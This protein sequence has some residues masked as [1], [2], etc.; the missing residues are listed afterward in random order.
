MSAGTIWR[1]VTHGLRTLV[2]RRRFEQ[3]LDDELQHW[4]EMA[5][6]QHE[7]NGLAPEAA[8]RRARAE[9]GGI[10]ATRERVRGGSWEFFVDTL[11]RDLRY[12]GRTLRRSPAFSIAAILT[13][14][15]GI[16]GNTTIFSL[17]N[18]V[19]LRPP[20]HVRMP[21][22]L[23]SVYTSD[24]SGPPH[25]TSSYADFEDFRSA[26]NVFRD[27][28]A[29]APRSIDVGADDALE[30]EGMELVSPNYFDLLGVRLESGRGF[31]P[32]EGKAG[33]PVPVAV[34]GDR[35]WKRR[36][37]GRREAIGQVIQLAGTSFTIIGI[38]PHGFV[39]AFRGIE[40]QV[41]IPVAAAPLVGAGDGDLMSRGDRSYFVMARLAPGVSIEGARLTMA[42]VARRLFEQ[43]PATW[44]DLSGKG[45]RITL[46][47]EFA[48][49]I[50]PQVRAPALGFMGLLLAT[51]GLVLL[52]CCA[53]VASLMI[54]RA[55]R[56]TREMGVRLAL[57][58][59]R[60]R[61]LR[62]LLTESTML[63]LAGGVVGVLLSMAA[64]S[65]LVSVD[66]P[67]PF[68]LSLDLALDRRVFGFTAGVAL[69]T[70]I[71]F[72]IAPARRAVRAQVTGMLRG[73]GPTVVAGRRFTLQG[74]LVVS[75]V[76]VS[77]LLLVAALGFVRSLRAASHVDTGFAT[78]HLLLFDVAVRPGAKSAEPERDVAERVR[79][80]LTTTSGVVAASWGSASPLAL[81]ASRRA[82]DIE[83]YRAAPGEDMEHYFNNVGPDYFEAMKLPIV[84][85][86]GVTADDRAGAPG[87]V[88]VSET[89][90]KRFWPGENPIGKRI[91]DRRR[92]N[93][94]AEVVGVTRDARFASLTDAVPPY[95]YFSALQRPNGMVFHVRTLGAPAEMRDVI[96]ARLTSVVPD[97]QLLNMRTMDAQ[98]GVAL[99]PQRV[100]GSLLSLFGVVAMLLAA[101]G[102]YGVVAFGVAARS[103]EI[104]VRIALGA[105]SGDVMLLILRQGG[106]LVL[107]GLAV[108]VPLA[109]AA[110][111]L[112]QSLFIGRD[113]ANAVAFVGAALL[114]GSVTFVATWIPARR[115][116]RVPPMMVL[117]AE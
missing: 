94:F 28:M 82:I 23:V 33:A 106:Q 105:R 113:S 86:R 81:D 84:R 89:F 15:I 16:G 117:R 50:P 26:S 58:A 55:T 37:A 73:E 64:T 2:R 115:A 78:D 31:I 39:G 109:M 69:L 71:V 72:G 98:L 36:Y 92:E 1:T 6:A 96:R 61:V 62:Q 29:F 80:A 25:G 44:R 114:L 14:G 59:T 93:E 101:I 46:E 112:M 111:R 21:E 54:S 60:G 100:A 74:A 70:G 75:Q 8:R 66:L 83:G 91:S 47:S 104:G 10:E 76:A 13:L 12:A 9:L 65:A 41:W 18:A 20:P 49:R 53:N 24:F 27:V 43:N 7:R 87:V 57:G 19:L 77:L 34:I 56:R 52:V 42:N 48:S 5:A 4:V 45:R 35:L 110:T 68:K 99:L 107:A 102:L 97:W 95:L 22:E 108:G 88:V 17:I 32:N 38:A 40:A 103:R 116:A 79:R 11:A 63:A 3:D 30:R 51:V 90:A 85:G 67:L